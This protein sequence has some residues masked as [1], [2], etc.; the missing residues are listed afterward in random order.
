MVGT[1]SI[2]VYGVRAGGVLITATYPGDLNN[3]P[4]SGSDTIKVTECI[5]GANILDPNCVTKT[6]ISSGSASADQAYSTNVNVTITGSMVR[7]GTPVTITSTNLGTSLPSGTTGLVTTGFY[8]LQVSGI[9]SGTVTVCIN[10]T[11]VAATTEMEYYYGGWQSAS[12]IASTPGSKVC[13]DIPVSALNVKTLIAV[14][15]PIDSPSAV[16]MFVVH[17]PLLRPLAAGTQLRLVSPT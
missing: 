14:G 15:T 9:T 10:G 2:T 6:T 3:A 17:N 1:C 13:G 12:N 7:D 11:Q 4:S 16:M 8:Y 5:A